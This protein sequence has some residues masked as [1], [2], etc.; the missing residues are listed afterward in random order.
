[1]FLIILM[2]LL[3][4]KSD[5]QNKEEKAI[6]ED[7][8]TSTNLIEGKKY[9]LTC[10]VSNGPFYFD[11]LLN[12]RKVTSN[13]NIVINNHED[14]S[15]LNIKSMSLEYAGD[16]TCQIK[17]SNDILQDSRTVSVKLNIKPRFLIEPTNIYAKL[18]SLLNTKCQVIAIPLAK[19]KWIKL[20]SNG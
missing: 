3:F 8:F 20:S 6:I 19:I 5:C 14:N 10:Q 13:D 11:W 15:Q 7:L 17:N 16:Y 1:M 9:S 18:N 2:L 4:K 12:K